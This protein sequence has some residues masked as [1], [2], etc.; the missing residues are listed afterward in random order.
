MVRIAF[1]PRCFSGGRARYDRLW[2]G[3]YETVVAQPLLRGASPAGSLPTVVARTFQRI[4]VGLEDLA[5]F[6][7]PTCTYYTLLGEQSSVCCLFI[8]FVQVFTR[9]LLGLY[10]KLL[11]KLSKTLVTTYKHLVKTN[12]KHQTIRRVGCTSWKGLGVKNM[13][14]IL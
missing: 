6:S 8:I 11:Y 2:H 14:T 5:I 10:N 12:N 1:V 4:D 3:P 9:V 7:T 13:V